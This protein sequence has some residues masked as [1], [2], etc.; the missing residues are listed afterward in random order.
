MRLDVF[1]KKHFYEKIAEELNFRGQ[2]SY[3]ELDVTNPQAS[4]LFNYKR[5]LKFLLHGYTEQATIGELDKF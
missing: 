4:K 1:L 2:S 3:S 5:S